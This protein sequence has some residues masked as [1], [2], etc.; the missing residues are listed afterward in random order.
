MKLYKWKK[1]DGKELLGM[2]ITL[3]IGM[4]LGAIAIY[5]DWPSPEEIFYKFI[6]FV[7][8]IIVILSPIIAIIRIARK[9]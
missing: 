9:F 1:G 7:I 8:A 3:I 6:G 5:F 2:L 4:L